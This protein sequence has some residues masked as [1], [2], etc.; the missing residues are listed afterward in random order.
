MLKYSLWN[1]LAKLIFAHYAAH[2]PFF[3]QRGPPARGHQSIHIGGCDHCSCR[4]TSGD[5]K[6]LAFN[7][8]CMRSG[9]MWK[10]VFTGM[11]AQCLPTSRV[12]ATT[13]RVSRHF[14]PNIIGRT[15]NRASR[16]PDRVRTA[17]RWVAWP[18]E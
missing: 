10:T 13:S 7:T 17:W 3:P 15:Q 2:C 11:R 12:Y 16:K 9:G 6:A 14:V 8:I 18:A 5:P 1:N 4:I